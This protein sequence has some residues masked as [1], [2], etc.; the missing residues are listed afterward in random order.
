[1]NKNVRIIWSVVCFGIYMIL[2][3]G[4]GCEGCHSNYINTNYEET[5]SAEMEEPVTPLQIDEGEDTYS[6]DVEEDERE[7]EE[8]YQSESEDESS[9]EYEE[10]TEEEKVDSAQVAE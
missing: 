10:T 2:A 1:M 5:D 4:S 8:T 7:E 6:A 9:E 3:A